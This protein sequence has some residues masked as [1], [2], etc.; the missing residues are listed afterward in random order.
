MT[1]HVRKYQK[2]SQDLTY[3]DARLCQG[4]AGFINITIFIY[5]TLHCSEQQ[6]PKKRSIKTIR[7]NRYEHC[8]YQIHLIK[9]HH[10]SSAILDQ[11]S[12]SSPIDSGFSTIL[13]TI[14]N[15][16][17]EHDFVRVRPERKDLGRLVSS[18]VYLFPHSFAQCKDF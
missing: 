2:E 10:D 3:T 6:C 15:N 17:I 1:K 9:V 8:T 18:S 14:L 13:Q 16:T 7:S 4:D 5:T 12:S 11:M